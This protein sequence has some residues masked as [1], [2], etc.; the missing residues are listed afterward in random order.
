MCSLPMR[1]KREIL[2]IGILIVIILVLYSFTTFFK[3]NVEQADA[4]KFVLEDLKGKYPT[5][6]VAI[7]EIKQK[8]NNYNEKYFEV[9]VSL[10]LNKGMPCPELYQYYYNYPVQNFV[11][12]PPEK[13]TS[14]CTV[15][16]TTPCQI[17]FE[18]EAAI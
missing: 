2:L 5:A 1:I 12:S 17:A 3:K 13:I 15:C 4:S 14:G 18:E 11:P 9:K 16:A 8:F 10:T 6:D 7:I